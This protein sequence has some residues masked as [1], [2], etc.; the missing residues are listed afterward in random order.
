MALDGG[1]PKVVIFAHHTEVI[2]RL[3]DLLTDHNPVVIHGATPIATRQKAID[4]FQTDDSVRVF[5]GQIN[6][7]GTAI[8]LTAASR[9]VMAEASW[10]PAENHQAMSRCHRIG[11]S[12]PVLVEF[13]AFGAIDAAIARALARKSADIDQMIG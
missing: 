11:Q 10:V 9:V 13:M 7:A 4:R 3:R 1:E 6:S 8:T 2:H 12:N 5:I